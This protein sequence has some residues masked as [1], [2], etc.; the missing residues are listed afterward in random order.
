MHGKEVKVQHA[1]IN[2]RVTYLCLMG[3]RSLFRHGLTS[4]RRHDWGRKKKGVSRE[5]KWHESWSGKKT[6]SH[7][8]LN[9]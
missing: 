6:A 1:E 2:Y 4:G 9:F 5:E 3:H 8:L 7:N